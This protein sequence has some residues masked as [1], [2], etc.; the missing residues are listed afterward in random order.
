VC[1]EGQGYRVNIYCL[2]RG[3]EARPGLVLR[4][5]KWHT[6]EKR[7]DVLR[8]QAPPSV[9]PTSP[10]CGSPRRPSQLCSPAMEKGPHGL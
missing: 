4:V 1:L 5:L 7:R 8:L 3:N 2:P 6:G 9:V 10:G